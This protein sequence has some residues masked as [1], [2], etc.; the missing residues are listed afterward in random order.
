MSREPLYTR[1][2]Y[3][4]PAVKA[5][6]AMEPDVA[7]T[8]A[9]ARPAKKKRRLKR[10]LTAFLVV[11]GAFT[12]ILYGTA[13]YIRSHNIFPAFRARSILRPA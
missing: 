1:P 8:V 11:V 3:P 4:P 7:V 6:M 9:E 13:S 10:R 5:T 2:S 12:G